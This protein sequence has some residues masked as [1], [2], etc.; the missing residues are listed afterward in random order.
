MAEED[1]V[2]QVWVG[3]VLEEKPGSRRRRRRARVEHEKIV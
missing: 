3:R 2:E 1:D